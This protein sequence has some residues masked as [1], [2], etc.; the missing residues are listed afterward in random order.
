MTY[1]AH[2]ST[3][4]GTSYSV[5]LNC[6]DGDFEDGYSDVT[7]YTYG[8]EVALP[9]LTK[10]GYTFEGWYDN[11]DFNGSPIEKI[12]ATDTGDKAFWAKWTPIP[13]VD[14]I[15]K[16]QPQ[17]LSLEYGKGGALRVEAESADADNYTLEYQW[18]IYETDINSHPWFIET[19]KEATYEIP[20]NAQVGTYYY[21][22]IVVARRNDNKEYKL[23]KSDVA[24]VE[25]TK[26]AGPVAPNDLKAVATSE[27]GLSDGKITGVTTDMEY[28]DT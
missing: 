11:K 21:Y 23:V 15:I 20:N 10:S 26:L 24:K 1:Y 18:Y 13:A 2:W 25:I 12:T 28:A 6:N 19:A 5:K 17:D 8:T 7:E 4:S 14:P 16:K 3:A 9:K 27:W 22:C